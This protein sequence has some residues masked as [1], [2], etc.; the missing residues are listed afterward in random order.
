LRETVVVA[1]GEFGRT[2]KI[3]GKAGRDHWN[4]C[5]CG[6]VAGGGLKPGLVIGSSDAQAEYPLTR[7]V[8]PADLFTTVL[9]QIGITTTRLIAVGLTPLGTAIE[10][11]T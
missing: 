2:P 5:Y 3:N 8:K 11:L 6:V 4:P 9:D 1:V 10:E 7:P